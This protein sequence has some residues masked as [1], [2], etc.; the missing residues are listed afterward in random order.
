MPVL[1]HAEDE[2]CFCGGVVNQGP[3]AVREK[4]KGISNESE[5]KHVR[6][7]VVM[8]EETGCHYHVCH[9][10]TKESVEAVRAAQAKGLKV[11]TEVTPHH[12]LLADSDIPGNDSNYKMNPPLR[13]SKD[14]E[15]MIEALRD[16]TIA[17]VAT[18]HAPH[19]PEEKKRRMEESPVGVVGLETA[20][21]LL[22]TELVLKGKLTL[23][24]LVDSLTLAPAK[25]FGL[26]YGRLEVGKTADVAIIDLKGPAAPIHAEEFFSKGRNTPFDGKP[27][28]GNVVLTLFG[29]IVTWKEENYFEI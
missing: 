28:Q 7:D 8:A 1:A 9:I 22:Y 10:S 24:R 4:L 14:R 12:L 25:V 6:R 21:P 26:P 3:F 11:T 16:G 5:F 18:D 29:G 13:S 20:F 17:M 27:V 19:T 23:A 2:E 15:A